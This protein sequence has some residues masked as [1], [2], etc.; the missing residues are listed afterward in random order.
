M[1]P[2]LPPVGSVV[3]EVILGNVEINPALFITLSLPEPA[4][5]DI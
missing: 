2:L 5:T 4:Y 3:P 1:S